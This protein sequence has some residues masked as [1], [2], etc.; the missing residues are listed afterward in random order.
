MC[1]RSKFTIKII[2]KHAFARDQNL[3]VK[4]FTSK[5]MYKRQL[6]QANYFTS[7]LFYKRTILQATTFT[8]VQAIKIYKRNHLGTMSAKIIDKD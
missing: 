7:K 5:I 3:Q 4:L 1:K 8:Y 6:L 2:Y